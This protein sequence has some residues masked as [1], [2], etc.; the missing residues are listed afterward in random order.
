MATPNIVYK[1]LGVKWLIQVFCPA[2]AFVSVDRESPAIPNVLYTSPFRHIQ[3]KLN[4]CL[5]VASQ[6]PHPKEM[7]LNDALN[8]IAYFICT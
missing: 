1:T 2:S 8:Q 5:P 3:L 7:C 6:L 4:F